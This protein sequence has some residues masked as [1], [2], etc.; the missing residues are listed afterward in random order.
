MPA[1]PTAR[2]LPR[3]LRRLVL[4]ASAVAA[5]AAIVS[6][7][8]AAPGTASLL[9]R[10]QTRGCHAWSLNGGPYVSRQHVRLRAGGSLTVTNDDPMVQQ[11]VQTRGPAVRMKLERE[12]HLGQ[13]P[14]AMRMGRGRTRWRT[15]AQR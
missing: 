11:L 6:P 10:H 4:G 15:W 9:V 8:A 1:A 2:R 7:L 14:T 3:T 5:F 13:M 12:S